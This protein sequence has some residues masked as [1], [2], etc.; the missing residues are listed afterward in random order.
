MYSVGCVFYIRMLILNV[1]LLNWKIFID[2]VII[3]VVWR[4]SFE[5]N[6]DWILI[7]KRR[8]KFKK[9]LLNEVFFIKLLVIRDNLFVLSKVY[10]WRR[11]LDEF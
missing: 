1:F 6:V 9:V 3:G 5:I 8:N 7:L 4:G 10:E 11:I 2:K